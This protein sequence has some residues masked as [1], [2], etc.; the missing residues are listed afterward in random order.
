M[1]VDRSLYYGGDDWALA[2]KEYVATSVAAFR[3]KTRALDLTTRKEVSGQRS[4]EFIRTW[5]A[6]EEAHVPGAEISGQS[7]EKLPL[8]VYFEDKERISYVEQ[9]KVDA[10]I[11]HWDVRNRNAIET[12]S[13]LARAADQ[14]VLREV[15]VGAATAGTGSFPGGQAL[16]TPR[17]GATVAL[18]YPLSLDG[19]KKMQDDIGEI[20]QKMLDDNVADDSE[21]YAFT[22]PY[23]VRVL[24]QDDSLLSSDYADRSLADKLNGKLLKVENCWIIP[25][26]NLPTADYSAATDPTIGGTGA[27]LANCTTLAAAI[28][29][30]DA[31]ASVVSPGGIDPSY[32]WV[33]T[34]RK[35]LIGAAW[36][37]GHK[38][39]RL[40]SCGAIHVAG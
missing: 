33:P 19:S 21:F 37:K 27:Y 22:S 14:H 16:T 38:A 23:V 6:S 10:I 24:R 29:G 30:P 25:T 17:T 40:E 1:P 4:S 11:A 34:H 36:L 20:L 2:K 9:S 31:I 26:T 35:W 32:D 39:F 12:G 18:G 13:A 28:I 8:I 3:A 15:V 5:L 7:I